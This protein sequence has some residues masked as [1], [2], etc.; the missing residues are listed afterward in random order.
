MAF[1]GFSFGG[2]AQ[3]LS[4]AYQYTVSLVF[5]A[6]GKNAPADPGVNISNKYPDLTPRQVQSVQTT[7]RDANLAGQALGR[8]DYNTPISRD[9]IPID[10]NIAPEASYKYTGT[11]GFT[12]PSTGQKYYRDVTVLAPRNLGAETVRS[13]M[14]IQGK[15]TFKASPRQGKVPPPLP[16]Q[17]VEVTSTEILSVFRRT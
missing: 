4:S 16:G 11:V 13:M 14:E 8:R 9:V 1:P 5:G 17:E 10:R 3:A 2:I 12:D 6:G 7:A 15:E